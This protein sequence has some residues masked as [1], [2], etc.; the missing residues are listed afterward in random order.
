MKFIKI[1]IFLF[2]LIFTSH[3]FGKS[4]EYY[5]RTM[6]HMLSECNSICQK[7]IFEQEVQH[8]F[9][10]LIDAVINQIEFEIS[11]KKKELMW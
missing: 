7:K 11:Q 5:Q 9:F 8:A 1:T 3:A 4:N 10:L 6:A 2:L